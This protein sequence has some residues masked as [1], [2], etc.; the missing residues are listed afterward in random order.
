MIRLD[1]YDPAQFAG[2][3]LGSVGYAA[4]FV[5]AA[6]GVVLLSVF[7]FIGIRRGIGFARVMLDERAMDAS[8]D[9]GALTRA[10]YDSMSDYDKGGY[11]FEEMRDR[12]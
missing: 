2:D 12:S 7:G 1:G 5:G 9:P 8:Y 10:Q 6:V 3:L 4:Q 11:S